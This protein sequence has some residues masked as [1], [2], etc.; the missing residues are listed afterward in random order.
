MVKLI[1][2]LAYWS[3]DVFYIPMYNIKLHKNS[4][5]FNHSNLIGVCYFHNKYVR[6]AICIAVDVDVHEFPY[7]LSRSSW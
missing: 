6:L 5:K 3:S 4:T 1:T 7:I 2:V